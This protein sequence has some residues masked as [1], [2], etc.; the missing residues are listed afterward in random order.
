M[1]VMCRLKQ[2]AGMI[3]CSLFCLQGAVMHLEMLF[4]VM[5]NLVDKRV[6]WVASRYDQ[7]HR[8]RIFSGT[9]APDMQIVNIG[10]AFQLAQV[11]FY[12]RRIDLQRHRIQ[13]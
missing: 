1:C 6:T 13:C 2:R 12:R 7:M 11:S 8:Q 9:Q 10:Y 3:G 5:R 4:Q